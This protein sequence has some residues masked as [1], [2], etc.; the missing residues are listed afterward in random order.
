VSDERFERLI[1]ADATNGSRRG[2]VSYYEILG[3][4]PDATADQIHSAY[5]DTVTRYHPDLNDGPDAE[6]FT[7]AI[8]EAWRTL[9]DPETRAAYDAR[10]EAATADVWYLLHCE[11][12]G[13][14]SPELRFV[15]F[16]VPSHGERTPSGALLCPRCRGIRARQTA[17]ACFAAA[18]LGTTP[19]ASALRAAARENLAGGTLDAG[20]NAALLRHLGL[21]YAQRRQPRE[22]AVAL[23]ASLTFA[24]D[25]EVEAKLSELRRG[26][27]QPPASP[28]TRPKRG[29]F[30]AIAIVAAVVVVLLVDA[31]FLWSIQ[32]SRERPIA[33]TAGVAVTAADSALVAAHALS[34]SE[35]LGAAPEAV[36]SSAQRVA[37]NA[38]DETSSARPPYDGYLYDLP[39]NRAF[40]VAWHNLVATVPNS[41]RAANLWLV[42]LNATAEP[43]EAIA[44]P[45]GGRY[46]IAW[47]CDPHDCASGSVEVAYNQRTGAICALTYVAGGWHALGSTAIDDRA[48]LLAAV[49]SRRLFSGAALPLRGE[50]AVAADR[51]IGAV[52][53]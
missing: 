2:R 11:R 37:A 25:A 22:A 34:G 33:A 15:A 8:N 1:H 44:T 53:D 49:A 42:G 14:A 28:Q 52:T 31:G 10:V 47:G 18:G 35:L 36:R 43:N 20:E 50:D 41:V 46:L 6:R 7:A 40:A 38:V 19:A 45:A 13:A 23:A 3:V 24:P 12:C 9:R 29:R 4:A 32:R 21:T 16:D 27:E 39:R 26:G 30:V 48:T 5:R 51:F 17:L